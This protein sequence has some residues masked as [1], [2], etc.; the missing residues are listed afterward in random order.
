MSDEFNERDEHGFLTDWAL[1]WDAIS[2]Y[3]CDCGEDASERCLPCL[4]EAA[5]KAERKRAE[6]AYLAG[7]NG[8][9]AV[10]QKKRD[11]WVHVHDYVEDFPT[12]E[13]ARSKILALDD[14]EEELMEMKKVNS[15][16][17]K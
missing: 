7:V 13:L 16:D 4:C 3:E 11:G 1:A 6:T 14:V 9:I 10:L 12:K 2:D 17:F 5:M 15:D 8:A